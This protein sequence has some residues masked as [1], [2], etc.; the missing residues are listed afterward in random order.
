[1]EN[2]SLFEKIEG[3]LKDE[4]PEAEKKAFEAE[5]QSDG[6]LATQVELQRFELDAIELLV[7]EDL[8]KDMA[9]WKSDLTTEPAPNGRSA[10]PLRWIFPLVILGG[11][12]FALY[13]FNP[14]SPND[15]DE[16]VAEEQMRDNEELPAVEAPQETPPDP[17]PVD[18]DRPV[19]ENTETAPEEAEIP[20]P[21]PAPEKA[22]EQL[23]T[24]PKINNA[25]VVASSSNY[26]E[27]ATQAFKDSY[28]QS[29]PSDASEQLKAVNAVY[30]EGK[31][32]ATVEAVQSTFA[33]SEIDYVNALE[34]S[35]A[36]HFRLKQFEQVEQINTTILQLG[37]AKYRERAEYNLM[38]ALVAQEKTMS[39]DFTKLLNKIT[40]D[41]DHFGHASAKKLK[42]EGGLYSKTLFGSLLCF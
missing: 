41:T 24:A 16:P 32:E 8:R 37:T 29:V 2:D 7:E 4:L 18:P 27:L 23:E 30:T 11:I 38:L 28:L 1:M 22:K 10:N 3:Y 20:T 31:Y 21:E 19:A 34:Y 42:R 26:L 17:D 36:A 13:F 5:I 14:F 39:V 15:T 9:A 25:P 35:S 6:Q 12:A 40:S 33:G